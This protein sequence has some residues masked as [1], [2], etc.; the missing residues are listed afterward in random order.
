MEN[1]IKKYIYKSQKFKF[2]YPK[3]VKNLLWHICKL[4]KNIYVRNELIEM[5]I[6]SIGNYYEEFNGLKGLKNS[7]IFNFKT[8][9]FTMI[10]FS[11]RC[12]Y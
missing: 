10:L 1:M 2:Y 9:D 5:I 7:E 6:Q 4:I 11:F 12:Q 8:L 3:S